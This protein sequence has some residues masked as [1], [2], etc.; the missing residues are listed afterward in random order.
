M[1]QCVPVVKRKKDEVSAYVLA[2]LLW[3][4]RVCELACMCVCWRELARA[5]SK[6][7]GRFHPWRPCSSLR[8]VGSSRPSARVVHNRQNVCFAEFR[9]DAHRVLGTKV[10]VRWC[11]LLAVSTELCSTIRVPAT[12]AVFARDKHAK[13]SPPPPPA[14]RGLL[15]ELKS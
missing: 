9:F 10:A 12:V 11:P 14:G 3:R 5:P 6:R 4:V 15:R 1:V 7:F 2:R 8:P 13:T